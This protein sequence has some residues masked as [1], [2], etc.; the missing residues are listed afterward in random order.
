MPHQLPDYANITTEDLAAACGAALQDCDARLGELVAVPAGQRTFV[1]T[2]LALEEARASVDAAMAAWCVLAEAYPD[3]S[4]QKC[5]REW[6][7]R[8]AK[9]TVGIELDEQVYRAVREYAESA[10]AA[11]LTGTDARLLGH[12]LRDYRRSGTDLPDV[13]RERVRAL[14]DELVE[15]DS[16]FHATLAAW[17]DGIV[18]ERGELDGLP[19]TFVDGLE[20]VGD[21][22]RVSLDYPEFNPFMAEARS[23]PRRRE[24]MEKFQRRGGPENLAR[25]ERALEVRRET[26]RILGYPSWAAYRLETR[27]AESPETVAAF[28]DDLRER[29]AV[30]AVGDRAEAA[31]VVE[32]DGGSREL[33]LWDLRYAQSRLKRERY[34]V[35]EAEVARYFPMDACL[36]AM[37]EITGTLLG[38]GFEEV[39]DAS[40]WHPDVRTFDMIE[41][42]DGMPV[43][44][45]HLDLFPRPEKYKHAMEEVLRHGRRLP[46]GSYQQPVVLMLANFTRPT[47]NAPSLLRHNELVV[48]FHEF[49]HVLHAALTRAEHLR[50]SGTA[51]DHDF[52]E[53]P[54][55]M[56][57][58]WCW[59][60]AVLGRL[61]RHFQTG[62]PMP[63]DLLNGLIAAKNAGSGIRTMH[64]LAYSTLD[65]AYHSPDYA[66]DSTATL[67]E[68]YAQHGMEHLEGTHL[69]S[70]FPHLF[71]YDCG[72][73]GYLW[74]QAIGDDLYTRFEAAGPLDQATGAD[75]RRIVLERGGSVDA[76]VMVREF[77][78]REP[79]NAAFLRG[80]GLAPAEPATQGTQGTQGTTT[81]EGS[82]P[83]D[84]AQPPH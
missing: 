53:A 52:V 44:R 16:A 33:R 18:V 56:L 14:R 51:A 59:E 47:A 73:Y 82:R 68:V 6:G 76:S 83:T 35:D 8:L 10:E 24:L 34:A 54:S 37:F 30:K 49:G 48:L 25:L 38:V 41:A 19:E 61:A 4:L 29:A 7:E 39:A 36:D 17:S 9:R 80:I 13:E 60:P 79:S 23:S 57:E 69:Q 27:M 2:V 70:G 15:L 1:N 58:N 84:V 43:A 5:A 64:A 21:R 50:Y 40:V 75:Y 28:L 72:Y 31:D 32:K 67:A 26:A 63:R 22:Y 42:S 46:D 45:F 77:L 66:G 55:Q 3:L 12:L 65:L 71:G 20:R 62:E 78:G 74:S 11:A 81:A